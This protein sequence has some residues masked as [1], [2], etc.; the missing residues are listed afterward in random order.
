MLLHHILD[1]IPE[2]HYIRPRHHKHYNIQDIKI[3]VDS[4]DS[5]TQAT[6]TLRPD[7]LGVDSLVNDT[8]NSA[9]GLVGGAGTGDDAS[10]LLW[11]MVTVLFA[12]T[13]CLYFVYAYRHRRALA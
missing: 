13:I 7:T 8:V 5:S 6:D 4:F 12:L 9:Q 2:G 1:V 10:M 3:Q 11:S